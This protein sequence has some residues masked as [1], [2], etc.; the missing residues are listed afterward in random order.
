MSL[1]ES[2]C[3]QGRNR[4]V[5]DS[6]IRAGGV[7]AA[8]FSGIITGYV[9]LPVNV[10]EITGMMAVTYLFYSALTLKLMV[11]YRK[12]RGHW[13]N[14]GD[15][16]QHFACYAGAC[17]AGVLSKTDVYCRYFYDMS[18]DEAKVL[19]FLIQCLLLLGTIK[20]WMMIIGRRELTAEESAVFD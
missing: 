8:V 9:W 16:L 18:E 12:V 4:R 20:V 6:K 1:K 13:F 19:G 14:F 2:C 10:R 3:L 11:G 15:I 17:L 7:L 5:S